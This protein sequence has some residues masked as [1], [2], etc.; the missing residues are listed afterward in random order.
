MAKIDVECIEGISLCSCG[1]V[2]IYFQDSC[3]INCKKDNMPKYLGVTYDFIAQL[4]WVEIFQD[5]FAC[6]HC[7]NHY[8]VDLCACGS[9]EEVGKCEG[10]FVDYC[11]TPIQSLNGD[12]KKAEDS[13]I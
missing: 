5:T 2:T 1:A 7:V 9:G 12:I 6:N 8:G 10:D 3:S 13:W 4:A 11:G